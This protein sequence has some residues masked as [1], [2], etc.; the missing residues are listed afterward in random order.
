[1]ESIFEGA[2]RLFCHWEDHVRWAF[3][4]NAD[5]AD[6]FFQLLSRA[7]IKWD[8]LPTPVVNK[9]PDG[10]IG[11]GVTIREHIGFLAV[12]LILPAY[13]MHIHIFGR[14][15]RMALITF[16]FSSRSASGL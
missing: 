15:G 6:F 5:L 16:T 1:M 3:E 7:Q 10:G 2:S 12:T 9:K 13:R 14:I 4:N 11:F 8:T